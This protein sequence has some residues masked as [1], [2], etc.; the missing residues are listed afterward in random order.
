MIKYSEI[1]HGIPPNEKKNNARNNLRITFSKYFL[2]IS[3]LMK[4]KI[5]KTINISVVSDRNQLLT[6]LYVSVAIELYLAET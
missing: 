6:I 1:Y 3:K 2:S 4:T 5:I